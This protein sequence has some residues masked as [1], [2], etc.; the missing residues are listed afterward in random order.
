MRKRELVH[1]HALLD[2]VRRFTDERDDLPSDA[3]EPYDDLDVA[4]T[5]VYRSK[6]SHEDAV[7]TLTESLAGALGPAA[8]ETGE[9]AGTEGA[10]EEHGRSSED[11]P[12]SAHSD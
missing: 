11:R 2:H 12:A 9:V 10:A 4:P 1:F 3:A 7:V 5:A 8:E 6:Q